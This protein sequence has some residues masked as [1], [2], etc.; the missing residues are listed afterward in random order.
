MKYSSRTLASLILVLGLS[1]GIARA[2]ASDTLPDYIPLLP[3]I[4]A[5]APA[6]DSKKGYVVGEGVTR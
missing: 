1:R 2:Q 3:Q 6:I 5:K 4:K